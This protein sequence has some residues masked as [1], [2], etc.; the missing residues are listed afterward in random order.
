MDH[1]PPRSYIIYFKLEFPEYYFLKFFRLISFFIQKLLHFS[2]QQ[3]YKGTLSWDWSKTMQEASIAENR[4]K[5]G[6]FQLLILNQRLHSTI[7][8]SKQELTLMFLPNVG[9]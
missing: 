4:L 2:P 3:M 6:P 7:Y 9:Y 5:T 1:P 8:I